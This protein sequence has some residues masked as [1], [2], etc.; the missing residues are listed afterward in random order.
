[1]I[2]TGIALSANKRKYN[3]CRPPECAKLHISPL[4]VP[5]F[6]ANIFKNNISDL[7]KKTS[8]ALFELRNK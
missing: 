8:F 4:F 6:F 2:T 3:P 5:I 1:M 7:F